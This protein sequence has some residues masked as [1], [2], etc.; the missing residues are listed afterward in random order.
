MMASPRWRT[1][2]PHQSPG[3]QNH[4]TGSLYPR[5]GPGCHPVVMADVVVV[6]DPDDDRLS[7]YRALRDRDLLRQHGDLLMCE[8]VLAV[9]RAA[10]LG[11]RL[12]TVLVTAKRLAAV[13]DLDT[14]VLVVDQ[15][16]M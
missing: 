4:A 6:D 2:R 10:E 16:V 9:R 7:P 13:E 14:E 3:V 1:R 5:P 8:G 15:T 12:R 11:V